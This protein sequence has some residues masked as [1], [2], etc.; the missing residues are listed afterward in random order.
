M[1][2]ES[3]EGIFL[4]EKR[5]SARARMNPYTLK[6]YHDKINSSHDFLCT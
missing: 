6:C 4:V 1:I 5:E 2:F 3:F